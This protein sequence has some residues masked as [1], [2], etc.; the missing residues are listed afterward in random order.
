MARPIGSKNRTPAEIMHD[1]NIAKTQAKLKILQEQKKA[2][3][4][5]K[6]LAQKKPSIK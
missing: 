2:R 5:A 3:N 1:A 4:E 6:K